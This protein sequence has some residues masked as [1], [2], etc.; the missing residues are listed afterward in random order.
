MIMQEYTPSE[1]FTSAVSFAAHN[2]KSCQSLRWCLPQCK[3]KYNP[4]LAIISRLVPVKL[5]VQSYSCWDTI[6]F[7]RARS[8]QKVA[9][10]L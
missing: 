8:R 4:G 3:R 9:L 10:P 7:L 1:F 2:F 6:R 5:T